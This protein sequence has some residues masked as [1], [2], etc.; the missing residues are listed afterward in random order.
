MIKFLTL[1]SVSV[2]R[3][4]R[5]EIPLLSNGEAGFSSELP[6]TRETPTERVQW[7][8]LNM[9]KGIHSSITTLWGEAEKAVTFSLEK[10]SVVPCV[11]NKRQRPQI[12]MQQVPSK[13]QEAFI[14]CVVDWAQHRSPRKVLESSSL[15]MFRNYLDMVLLLKQRCWSG[16][17]PGVPSNFIHSVITSCLREYALLG[18]SA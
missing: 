12:E 17:P 9:M 18:F 16:W 3:R 14:Y 15:E 11:R 6:Y 8:G 4:Y 2:V 5:E 13:H 1:T 10:N 7:M